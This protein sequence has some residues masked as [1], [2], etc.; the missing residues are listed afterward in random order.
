[1]LESTGKNLLKL[2][3]SDVGILTGLLYSTNIR[4]IL[5]DVKSINL[6]SVYETVVAGNREI[7]RK[8]KIIYLPIYYVMFL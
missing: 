8:G 6:G 3:L 4:A 5:D 7:Y 2:Y 1:M